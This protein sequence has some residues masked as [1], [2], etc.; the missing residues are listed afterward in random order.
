MHLEKREY[1]KLL[2]WDVLSGAL[3]LGFCA[4]ADR[5]LSAVHMASKPPKCSLIPVCPDYWQDI[6]IILLKCFSQVH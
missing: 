2:R 4:S 5:T 1:E 6:V 3:G